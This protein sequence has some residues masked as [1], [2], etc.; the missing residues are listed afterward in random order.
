MTKYVFTLEPE[1][2]LYE[3]ILSIKDLAREKVGEQQYL[4]DEPHLTLYVSNL[5]DIKKWDDGLAKI[6]ENYKDISIDIDRWHLFIDDPITHKDT[7]TINIE[8]SSTII[9]HNLQDILINEL[10]K[11]KKDELLNRYKNSYN[12]MNEEFKNNVDYCGY[13]FAGK[14]WLPHFGIASFDKDSFNIFWPLVKDSC[15]I[16]NY[17]AKA[18]NVYELNELDDSLKKIKSYFIED[19]NE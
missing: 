10:V 4:K 19:N 16:G 7:I 6:V 11:F 3:K 18:I 14:I 1:K 9:L 12:N 13:P 5:D 8:K 2:N 15:P 17:F